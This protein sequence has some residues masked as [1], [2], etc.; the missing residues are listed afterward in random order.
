MKALNQAIMAA[1]GPGQ[2]KCRSAKIA[3]TW[4]KMRPMEMALKRRMS[5][6]SM[7]RHTMNMTIMKNI[8]KNTP[9]SVLGHCRQSP[10]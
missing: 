3:V 9:T 6:A 5:L 4:R 1:T 7:G 2:L 10:L 8:R